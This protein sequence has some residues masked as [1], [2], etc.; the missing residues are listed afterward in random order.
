MIEG[1]PIRTVRAGERTSFLDVRELW[2]YRDFL[3]FWARQQLLGRYKQT[4]L[5]V[6]W[7]VV[8]PVVYMIVFTLL[9]GN[10]AGVS[11][12]GFP[13]P[14][15]SYLGIIAWQLFSTTVTRASTSIVG[16]S[17]LVRQVYFP[18]AVLPLASMGV[19]LVDYLIAAGVLV[20][21]MVI[22]GVVP[23]AS[24]VLLLVLLPVTALI[25]AGIGMGFG[26]INVF[27]RDIGYAL[28]FLLQ[29]GLFATPAVYPASAV[30]ERWAFLYALNPA[31]GLVAAHRAAVLGTPIDWSGLAISVAS[32][33]VLASIGVA[34]FLRLQ[35][36]FAD[37]V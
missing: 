12:E 32:G 22:Y 2:A 34:V 31:S 1:R 15:F 13:Y 36:K 9:L 25:A 29:V 24:T 17:Y 21:L 10:M 33:V 6:A 14:V 20:V 8:N 5:G 4:V 28:P 19:A 7:A 27:R 3:Y 35:R 11:S 30:P 37:Y 18:R 16:S 23:A 26:A